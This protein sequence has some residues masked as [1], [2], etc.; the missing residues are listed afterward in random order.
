[1]VV[2]AEVLTVD[3]NLDLSLRLKKKFLPITR[4][5]VKLT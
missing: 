3:S 1:M 2:E 5:D 4:L